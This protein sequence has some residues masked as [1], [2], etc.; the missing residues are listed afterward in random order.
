MTR[1]FT[2]RVTVEQREPVVLTEH[3]ASTWA[4][5]ADPPAVSDETW[6]LLTG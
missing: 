2:F 5:P 6:A 1:Q 3:D 4:A